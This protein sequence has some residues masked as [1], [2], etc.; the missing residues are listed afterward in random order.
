MQTVSR[1]FARVD[2]V[3]AAAY[4]EPSSKASNISTTD[5]LAQQDVFF[6]PMI[7]E[8]IHRVLCMHEIRGMWQKPYGMCQDAQSLLHFHEKEYLFCCK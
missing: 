1:F 2:V 3:M 5:G 4:R 7:N 8:V 6:V